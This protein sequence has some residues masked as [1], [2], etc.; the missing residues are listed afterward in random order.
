MGTLWK[1]R[2]HAEGSVFEVE[3]VRAQL[4]MCIR[5]VRVKINNR[6]FER[7]CVW[8]LLLPFHLWVKHA[9]SPSVLSTSPLPT[10][11]K[12]PVVHYTRSRKERLA[13]DETEN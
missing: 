12:R 2:L 1:Q 5:C 11:E 10:K 3:A 9:L 6:S 8:I 4:T 7:F 13:A